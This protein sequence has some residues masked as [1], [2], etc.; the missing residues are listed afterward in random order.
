MIR[1]V[2]ISCLILAAA[3]TAAA[4]DDKKTDDKDPGFKTIKTKEG[5]VFR[6]P[7]DMAIEVRDGI[8]VPQPFE[9]Y[10]YAK[11]KKLDE[12]VARIEARIEFNDE[13]PKSSAPVQPEK[14]AL[15]K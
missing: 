14:R 10:I 12:R 15:S 11:F 2:W 7:E 4:E 5:L 13:P 3:L 9:E 6:V 8:Q 1:T